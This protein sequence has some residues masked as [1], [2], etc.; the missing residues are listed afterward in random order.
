MKTEPK[1]PRRQNQTTRTKTKPKQTQQC[2]DWAK[3][4]FGKHPHFQG[5]V[6]IKYSMSNTVSTNSCLLVFFYDIPKIDGSTCSTCMFLMHEDQMIVE[7]TE[8]YT[9]RTNL[10]T[11][12]HPRSL[13]VGDLGAVQADVITV[14]VIRYVIELPT[15]ATSAMHA[16]IHLCC[17]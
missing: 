2:D 12:R 4:T 7:E 17:L 11:Y 1:T 8:A 9:R 15:D 6:I 14:A 16:P 10:A 13:T 5:N 3:E